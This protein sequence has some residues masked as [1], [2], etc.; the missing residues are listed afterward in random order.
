MEIYK[1]PDKKF[2]IVILKKLNKMQEN[3]D[4]Q[5]N[6]CRRIMNEQNE[7]INREIEII[8]KNQTETLV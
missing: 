2:K 8:N 4:R 5:L 6:K 3:T 7:V 1:L